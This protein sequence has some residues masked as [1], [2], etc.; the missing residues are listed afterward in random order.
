MK[1]YESASAVSNLADG[2]LILRNGMQPGPRGVEKCSHVDL[3]KILSASLHLLF[4]A[5][6][7]GLLG[8]SDIL[9]KYTDFIKDIFTKDTPVYGYYQRALLLTE[10]RILIVREVI[11]W[12]VNLTRIGE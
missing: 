1:D 2:L 3:L 8:S 6:G 12:N 10:A 4:Y 7:E 5:R 9:K 11:C